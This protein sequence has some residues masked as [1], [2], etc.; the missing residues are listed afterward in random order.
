MSEIVALSVQDVQ[1]KLLKG[2]YHQWLGLEV[3]AV[4]KGEITL[5]AR[6]R[7][8]WV[9]NTAGGYIHGG[10]LA[11]LVDLTADWALVAYTGK[12][13]PTLDIR[14]DYHR[15]ARGDLRIVGKVIKVGKQ[16]S[17][18]E[19]WVYDSEDRLVASGRGLYAMPAA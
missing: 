18:A 15:P 19:A 5:T 7:D 6:F 12:G 9:V 2:P 11:A 8:E 13:V 17:S 10:I 14:V 1:E 16:V 4:A 3:Q